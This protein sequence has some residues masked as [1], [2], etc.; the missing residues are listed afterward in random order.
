MPE[1][2]DPRVEYFRSVVREDW[3]AFLKDD[4]ANTH[5]LVHEMDGAAGLL[6]AG[7][8]RLFPRL[9]AGISGEQRRVDAKDPV[10]KCLQQRTF[11]TGPVS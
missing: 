3:H 11:A 7:I 10:K 9:V 1:A 6:F 5:A 4:R 2:L 8:Q